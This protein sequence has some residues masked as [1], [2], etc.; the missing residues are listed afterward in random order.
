VDHVHRQSD[1]QCGAQRLR[2]DEVTTMDDG[3]SAFGCTRAHGLRQR[4]GAIVTI[5]YDA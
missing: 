3:R 2:A 5:G 4:L 1:A